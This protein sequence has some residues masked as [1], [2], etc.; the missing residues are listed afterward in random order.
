[1]QL[2]FILSNNKLLQIKVYSKSS[3]GVVSATS[4]VTSTNMIRGRVN[5]SS[6]MDTNHQKTLYAVV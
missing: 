4:G 5:M 1:M 6:I 3:F 2:V